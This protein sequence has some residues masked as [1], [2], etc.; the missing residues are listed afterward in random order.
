MITF[1]GKA[2]QLFRE[3]SLIRKAVTLSGIFTIMELVLAL[4]SIA[5]V[6]RR[7]RHLAIATYGLLSNTALTF[8][9]AVF[10]DHDD[11]D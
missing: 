11:E 4:F 10:A 9:T 8:L 7:K 1:I 3:E 5:D 2:I 6:N